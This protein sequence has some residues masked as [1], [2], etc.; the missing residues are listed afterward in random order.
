MSKSKRNKQLSTVTQKWWFCQ[1]DE[2]NQLLGRAIVDGGDHLRNLRHVLDFMTRGW[3]DLGATVP[4]MTARGVGAG[5][6]QAVA[7]YPTLVRMVEWFAG[8][9]VARCKL[10]ADADIAAYV[11]SESCWGAQCGHL[12]LA[13]ARKGELPQGFGAFVGTTLFYKIEE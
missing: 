10:S 3:A 2:M 5:D 7:E 13:D 11:P 12:I 8:G 4:V 6:T 1:Q 9:S